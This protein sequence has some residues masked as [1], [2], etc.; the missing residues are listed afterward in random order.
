MSIPPSLP[1]S[2]SLCIVYVCSVYMFHVGVHMCPQAS[3]SQRQMLGVSL[4]YSSLYFLKQYLSLNPAH[5]FNYGDWP[6][7]SRDFLPLVFA[8]PHPTSMPGL[9]CAAATGFY[10]GAGDSNPSPPAS[11]AH[12]LLTEP[13]PQPMELLCFLP[14][15]DVKA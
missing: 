8:L 14:S 1:L 4:N 13:C 12:T 9:Q 7:S 5:Q 2:L 10:M 15:P 11:T 6:I 3:D